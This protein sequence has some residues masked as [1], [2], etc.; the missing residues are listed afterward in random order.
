WNAD[1]CRNGEATLSPSL[2]TSGKRPHAHNASP[3][4]RQCHAHTD[5]L[6]GGRAIEDHILESWYFHAL[7]LFQS[8]GIDANRAG[9]RHRIGPM[10]AV[11]LQV[12]D[13]DISSR[14]QLIFEFLW[15]DSRKSEH[16]HES[17]P[18]N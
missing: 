10:G 17:E 3:T 4:E 11:P 15:R 13:E 18:T 16:A 6:A 12:D 9:D 8:P 5:K 7:V 14:I 2:N 1:H